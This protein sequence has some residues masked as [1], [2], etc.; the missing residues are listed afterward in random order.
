MTPLA[1]I[2]KCKESMNSII[3]QLMLSD[4]YLGTGWEC[5]TMITGSIKG[6][7]EHFRTGL[8]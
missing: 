6:L 7:P 4:R 1:G 2:D 5:K 3:R 8:H